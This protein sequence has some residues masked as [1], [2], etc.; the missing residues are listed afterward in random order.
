[1]KLL[2][3]TSRLVKSW[4]QWVGEHFP[5]VDSQESG[6]QKSRVGPDLMQPLFRLP[7]TPHEVP[8]LNPP[9][10]FHLV[11]RSLVLLLTAKLCYGFIALSRGALVL[12]APSG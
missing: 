2:V 3:G 11:D 4:S 10:Q 12:Y 7:M 9:F 5:E 8:Y 1:M 6:N